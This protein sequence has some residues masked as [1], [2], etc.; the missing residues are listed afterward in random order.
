MANATQIFN[1]FHRNSFAAM[2]H[3]SKVWYIGAFWVYWGRTRIEIHQACS[4]RGRFVPNFQDLN[5][6]ASAADWSISLNL[7]RELDHITAGTLQ[8]FKFKVSQVMFT[9]WR[10]SIQQA[11]RY[12][13]ETDRLTDFK[14]RMGLVIKA[15]NDWSDVGWPQVARRHKYHIL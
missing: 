9:A 7:G 3:I 11:K 6:Y 10:I 14:L 8:A 15:E 13:S 12:K 2:L 4:L 5:R 1:F